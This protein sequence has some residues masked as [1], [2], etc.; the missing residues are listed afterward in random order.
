MIGKKFR[1]KNAGKVIFRFEDGREEDMAEGLV[2]EIT[3]IKNGKPCGKVLDDS[4]PLKKGELIGMP[5]MDH[6]V[7]IV[8]GCTEGYLSGHSGLKWL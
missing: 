3:N 2:V 1:L 7:E 5:E 8:D 6:W 4:P